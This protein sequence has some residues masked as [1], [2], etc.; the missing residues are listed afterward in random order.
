MEKFEMILL[1]INTF[2]EISFVIRDGHIFLK[3]A[4][5]ERSY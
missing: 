1:E 5:D 2:H 4:R 3:A